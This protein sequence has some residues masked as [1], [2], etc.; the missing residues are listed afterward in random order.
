M[1]KSIT[2]TTEGAKSYE[3]CLRHD[4]SE[5]AGMLRELG[6][7]RDQKVCIVTDSNVSPLYA[8]EGIPGTIRSLSTCSVSSNASAVKFSSA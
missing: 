8:I 6:Y 3:I 5:L 7:Q 2:V 1:A 4:F